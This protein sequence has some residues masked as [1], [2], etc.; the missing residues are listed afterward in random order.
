MPEVNETPHETALREFQEETGSSALKDELSPVATLTGKT[1]NKTLEIFLQEWTQ[2]PENIY[3][4]T[5]C[6]NARRRVLKI[7]QY[8][9]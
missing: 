8:R 5:A 7:H 9:A 2:P 1:S 3:V 4:F 6:D